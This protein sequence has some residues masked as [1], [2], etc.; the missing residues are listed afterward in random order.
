MNS[1]RLLQIFYF[2]FHNIKI[3]KY[4]IFAFFNVAFFNF[5][6]FNSSNKIFNVYNLY[7]NI[8]KKIGI[9]ID[10]SKALVCMESGFIK[11]DYMREKT[12]ERLRAIVQE[13][14]G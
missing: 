9:F 6:L 7:F 12:I 14:Q 3:Y 4:K 1:I 5:I 13:V 2:H 8:K 11:I 10:L